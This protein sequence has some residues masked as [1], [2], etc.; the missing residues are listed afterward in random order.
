MTTPRGITIDSATATQVKPVPRGI[1]LD[2]TYK[3]SIDS[4]PLAVVTDVATTMATGAA[5]FGAE[6]G[7]RLVGLP[8]G[9]DKSL[10]FGEAAREAIATEPTTAGGKRFMEGLGYLVNETKGL[11]D[12]AGA[13]VSGAG[14]LL[15]NLASGNSFDDSIS[16]AAQEIEKTRSQGLAP[17]VRENVFEATGSPAAAALVGAAPETAFL[18]AGGIKTPSTM[19][20]VPTGAAGAKVSIFPKAS[21]PNRLAKDVRVSSRGVLPRDRTA[22]IVEKAGADPVAIAAFDEL[23]IAPTAELIATNAEFINLTNSIA[24]RVGANLSKERARVI[25]DLS[26]KAD[27]L[28]VSVGGKTDRST[29]AANVEAELDAT[30]NG[31]SNVESTAWLPINKIP[32]STVVRATGDLVSYVDKRLAGVKGE[33]GNLSPMDK[34]IYDLVYERV[35][36]RDT[37]PDGKTRIRRDNNG[38]V[39]Y[40][41]VPIETTNEL[42]NRMR[43]K[44]GR[45]GGKLNPIYPD[46]SSAAIGE[47]YG[48]LAKEQAAHIPPALADQFKVANTLTVQR[49][50]LEKSSQKLRGKNLDKGLIPQIESA[51]NALVKGNVKPF[52]NLM[53]EIPQ[54]SRAEAAASVLDALMKKPGRDFQT[55]FVDRFNGIVANKETMNELFRHFP[56]EARRV[57]ENIGIVSKKLQLNPSVIDSSAVQ[58]A[59]TN[60]AVGKVLHATRA[61]PFAGRAI[62]GTA[63]TLSSVFTTPHKTLRTADAF[64]SSPEF[65]NAIKTHA[66]GNAAG[67]NSIISR[68]AHYKNWL[69]TLDATLRSRIVKTGFVSWLLSEETE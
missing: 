12:M 62:E 64:L 42:L 48:I 35:P 24:G 7:G 41:N 3:S 44:T 22:N 26:A 40:D 21:S 8:F 36:A 43:A 59:I 27:E 65:I 47:A 29:V 25:Q 61:I 4:N 11:V 51:S 69:A 55:S 66:A 68:S 13:G 2:D 17:T 28:V 46:S 31:L 45:A 23:G 56:P 15:S 10:E 60:G 37:L 1:V 32:G 57:F 63:E 34:E 20:R 14:Q 49:K 50:A 58:A 19:Q 67:A 5:G 9:V 52:R 16:A 30:I 18:A 38:K 39:V 53:R 6:L 54:G 33:R